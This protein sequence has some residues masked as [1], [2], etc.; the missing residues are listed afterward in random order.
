MTKWAVLELQVGELILKR[1][2]FAS[3]ALVVVLS[4]DALA[5]SNA[6]REVAAALFAVDVELSDGGF[7]LSLGTVELL[8]RTVDWRVLGE[9]VDSQLLKRLPFLLSQFFQ[10]LQLHKRSRALPE[11]LVEVRGQ[12]DQ[13]VHLFRPQFFL[14][15]HQTHRCLHRPRVVLLVQLPLAK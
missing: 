2:V 5:R 12:R 11:S 1:F 13:L 6:G 4:Q 7:A 15:L 14:V 9:E 10:S 8:P 3:L